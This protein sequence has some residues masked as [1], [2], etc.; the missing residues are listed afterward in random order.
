MFS[1]E[2]ILKSDTV[3]AQPQVAMDEEALLAAALTAALV[4]YRRYV[5][6]RNAQ[7]SPGVGTNW[8]TM[9]CV[10]RLARQAHHR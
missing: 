3:E 9:A 6:Q 8:R 1:L 4:E 10:E 5:Q 7:A 2:T